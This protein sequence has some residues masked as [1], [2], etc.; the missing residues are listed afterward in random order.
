MCQSVGPPFPPT[1]STPWSMCWLP[2][3]WF[4]GGR[5]YLWEI[6]AGIIIFLNVQILGFYYTPWKRAVFHREADQNDE[7][8][9]GI[10]Q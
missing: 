10:I 6:V 7:G 5:R 3:E 2:S 1:S 9:D 4:G 8:I